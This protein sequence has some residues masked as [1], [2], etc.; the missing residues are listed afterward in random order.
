MKAY[1][2]KEAAFERFRRKNLWDL[3][4]RWWMEGKREEEAS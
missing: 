2:S 1:E 4:T 3:M